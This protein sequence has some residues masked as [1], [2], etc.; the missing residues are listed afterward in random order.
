MIDSKC[1][2]DINLLGS[3][4]RWMATVNPN[5]EV[6]RVNK[7]IVNATNSGCSPRFDYPTYN[8]QKT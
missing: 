4:V 3:H 2:N 7:D 1:T 8:Y 5:I 6:I